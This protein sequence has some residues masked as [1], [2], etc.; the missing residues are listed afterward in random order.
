MKHVTPSINV[1]YSIEVKD[2][3]KWDMVMEFTRIQKAIDTFN[4]MKEANPQD[5]FRFIRSEWQVVE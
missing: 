3:N 2:G 4:E 1:K 5:E